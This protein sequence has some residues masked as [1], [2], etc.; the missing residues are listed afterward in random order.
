MSIDLD[1]IKNS[2]TNVS[3]QWFSLAEF[4]LVCVWPLSY[5][6][7]ELLFVKSW[8]FVATLVFDVF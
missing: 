1:L 2:D 8:H 6:G 7:R 4:G 5:L 3:A